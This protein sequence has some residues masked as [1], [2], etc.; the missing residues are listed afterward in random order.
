MQARSRND[1]GNEGNKKQ[2]SKHSL[3]THYIQSSQ[4]SPAPCR[5]DGSVA[6]VDPFPGERHVLKDQ[7][8]APSLT[9]S[10]L[11]FIFQ[12]RICTDVFIIV[13]GLHG[14]KGSHT[15]VLELQGCKVGRQRQE[16]AGLW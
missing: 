11:N 13:Q 8:L 2:A 6:D 15:L 12:S 4:A 16:G 1:S 7:L 3:G 5:A 9:E 14:R 10:F